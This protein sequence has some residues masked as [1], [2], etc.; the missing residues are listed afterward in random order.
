MLLEVGL[1]SAWRMPVIRRRTALPRPSTGVFVG[2]SAMIGLFRRRRLLGSRRAQQIDRL[3]RPREA[4]HSMVA[5]GPAIRSCFDLTGPSLS[6]DTAC[7]S[8][9]VAVHLGLPGA[10]PRRVRHGAGRRAS[11]CC[12]DSAEHERESPSPQS[13]MLSP[14][15]RCKAFS[16]L[17]DGYG[18]AEG[19]GVVVLRR[20]SDAVSLGDRVLA[21][22][23]GSA[24][25]QDGATSGLTVPERSVAG[26]G[27]PCG[28]ARRRGSGVG[29]RP[30]RGARDRDVA[31]RS[32]RDGRAARR[33]RVRP[34]WIGP[35]LGWFGEDQHRA[36]RGCGG[37]CRP[38][39]AGAVAAAS[40]HPGAPA[41]GPGQRRRGRAS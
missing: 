29:S 21:V 41:S 37:D 24:V 30:D 4:V 10:A 2:R 33:V 1:G 5:S 8:S 17:A 27:D 20:L 40:L 15:G 25:N 11:I 32:D 28:V 9:L 12:M 26:G 7:S 16:S 38:D 39:Q 3:L 35:A 13:R 14:D 6:V 36:C 34:G 22:I 19:C 31:R 18:R 23:R